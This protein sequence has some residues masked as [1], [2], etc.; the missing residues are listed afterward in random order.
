MRPPSRLYFARILQQILQ[1]EREVMLVPRRL[2]R[3][4]HSLSTLISTV[5]RQRAQIV[6]LRFDQMREI[7]RAEIDLQPAGV[8]LRQEQEI[9]DDARDAIGLVNE[10]REFPRALRVKDSRVSAV[11]RVRRA[12]P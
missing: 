3:A 11:L 4:G 2:A 6:Q 1:D 9:F 10:R 7:D 5:V 8:H 12:T